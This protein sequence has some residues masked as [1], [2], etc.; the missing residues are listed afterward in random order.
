M[1]IICK[2]EV[3]VS[4]IQLMEKD[5]HLFKSIARTGFVTEQMLPFIK[6]TRQRLYDHLLNGNI[7]KKGNFLIFDSL[8]N[9][10]VLTEKTKKQMQNDFLIDLYKSDITRLEHDFVL[11]KI[12]MFLHYMERESWK[13]ESSLLKLY[14]GSEKPTDGMY[15]SKAGMKIGVEVITDRYTQREIRQKKIFIKHFCDDYIMIHT[16]KD[17]DY[18]L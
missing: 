15:I 7:K 9:V 13:T 12:Y 3:K 2:G 5:I 14:S 1:E 6:I 11:S 8:T 4:R 10:Y 16:H 17:I 18:E